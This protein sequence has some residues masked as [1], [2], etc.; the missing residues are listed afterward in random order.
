[1]NAFALYSK[2]IQFTNKKKNLSF[3]KALIKPM[4]NTEN[5]SL[6]L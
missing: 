5:T 2:V 4:L 1:M 3:S 6:E